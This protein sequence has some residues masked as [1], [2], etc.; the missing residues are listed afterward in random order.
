MY[1]NVHGITGTAC[2][3]GVYALTNDLVIAATVGGV[4]AFL[5]HDLM[6]RFGEHH[7]PSTKFFLIFEGLLFSVFCFLAW[8]SNLT[9]LYVIGWIGGNIMDLVDKKMGLSIYNSKKYPFGNFFPCHWRK[10]NI[11][12]T[13]NQTIA[14]SILATL[15]LV[16]YE[17]Y[18]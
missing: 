2:T 10:P 13:L 14:V 8:Q 5:S 11:N 4:L 7:Y 1:P 12:L 15:I 18:N 3:L 16:I 9:W 6:D 17:N